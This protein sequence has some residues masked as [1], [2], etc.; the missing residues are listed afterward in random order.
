MSP[1]S[2]ETATLISQLLNYLIEL[3]IHY[4]F[5]SGTFMH[6][7]ADAFII[8]SFTDIFI[9]SSLFNSVLKFNNSSISTVID[10]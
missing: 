4:E 10:K 6:D 2:V 5:A 1:L 3:P 9:P 7:N 8:I